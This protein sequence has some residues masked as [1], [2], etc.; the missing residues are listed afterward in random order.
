MLNSSLRDYSNGIIKITRTGA[1][2]AAIPA[3]QRNK[4]VIF[5]YFAPF[6][7]F[8]S[9]IKPLSSSCNLNDSK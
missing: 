2:Q 7:D 6:T 9:E 3:E 4:G 8:I 1:D 5:K